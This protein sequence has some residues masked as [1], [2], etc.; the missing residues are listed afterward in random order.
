MPFV[1]F[2]VNLVILA[3]VLGI[4]YLIAQAILGYLGVPWSG[5]A[6]KVIGLL[7]LLAVA[8]FILEALAGV[9]PPI[10]RWR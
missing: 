4:V 1:A 8:I 9:G 3:V 10:F 5:L 2:I 7:C 6:L